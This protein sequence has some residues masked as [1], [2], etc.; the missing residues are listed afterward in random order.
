MS[1]RE[2][3]LIAGRRQ[4]QLMRCSNRG[5]EYEAHPRAIGERVLVL[6]CPLCHA[7]MLVLPLC[8]PGEDPSDR[9]RFDL[10]H[11]EEAILAAIGQARLN[12]AKGGNPE[13]VARFEAIAD[14]YTESLA[15]IR[16]VGVEQEPVG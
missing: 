2:S 15:M 16:Q 14:T 10:E 4:W 13:M 7:A 5:C 12:A 11:V 6:P 1:T 9:E 8:V 3:S